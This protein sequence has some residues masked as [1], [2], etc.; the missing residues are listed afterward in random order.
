MSAD[1]GVG[2]VQRSYVGD[3]LDRQV[4]GRHE[5]GAAFPKGRIAASQASHFLPGAP[6]VTRGGRS[7]PRRSPD[8]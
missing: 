2:R 1:S 5:D 3:R 4:L 6:R 8:P 7:R